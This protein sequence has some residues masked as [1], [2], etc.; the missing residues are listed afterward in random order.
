MERGLVLLSSTHIQ[1]T[2][3]R[4]S[5]PA[6]SK[7]C[8]LLVPASIPFSC[9][10]WTTPQ[11]SNHGEGLEDRP[12]VPFTSMCHP[13]FAASLETCRRLCS[14]RPTGCLDR[15]GYN[16]AKCQKEVMLIQASP[17]SDQET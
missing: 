3:P 2:R 7:E 10:Q 12:A 6:I 13:E 15:S 5:Q 9:Q 14:N 4:K 1:K 16:E 11:G 17:S 8:L